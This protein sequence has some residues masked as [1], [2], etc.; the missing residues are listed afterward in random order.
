LIRLSNFGRIKIKVKEMNQKVY[1]NA[2]QLKAST[3]SP[4]QFES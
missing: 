2:K 4:F 3:L 1:W